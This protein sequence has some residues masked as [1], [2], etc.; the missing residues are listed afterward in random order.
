MN[1]KAGKIV[2]RRN[3]VFVGK[4]YH[5]GGLFVLNVTSDVVN[6]NASSSVTLLRLWIYGIVDLDM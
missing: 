6:R 4:G 3:G 2:F 5:S 1:Q